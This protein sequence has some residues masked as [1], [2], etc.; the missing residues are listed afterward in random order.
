LHED[1]AFQYG[2]NWFSVLHHAKRRRG[3]RWNEHIVPDPKG[4]HGKRSRLHAVEE[5]H[6]VVKR[7]V[8]GAGITGYRERSRTPEVQAGVWFKRDNALAARTENQ[9]ISHGKFCIAG[10]G[11]ALSRGTLKNLHISILSFYRK[12]LTQYKLVTQQN[13]NGDAYNRFFHQDLPDHQKN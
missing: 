1:L 7:Q 6:A 12:R 2:C 9:R 13:G 10:D 5:Q 8:G 4:E 11:N 3:T